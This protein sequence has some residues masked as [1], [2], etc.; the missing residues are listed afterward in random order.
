AASM[1]KGYRVGGSGS[2]LDPQTGEPMV[3]NGPL[4][5]EMMYLMPEGTRAL[6]G[7]TPA[8]PKQTITT[9]KVCTTEGDAAKPQAEGDAAKPPTNCQTTVEVKMKAA[10]RR[11]PRDDPTSATARTYMHPG[12]IFHD[13]TQ[14][15]G[16]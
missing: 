8:M 9:T 13:H 11:D 14:L 12:D 6:Q 16:P 4:S 15:G 1:P 5:N 7:G 2:G 3:K 10:P